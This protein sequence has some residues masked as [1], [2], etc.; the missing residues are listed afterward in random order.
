M[1]KVWMGGLF[2]WSPLHVGELEANVQHHPQHPASQP[3]HTR[4]NLEIVGAHEDVSN[5]RAH[6]AQDPLIKVG[7]F[8]L[9]QRV[10]H[11]GL[12]QP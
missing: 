12:N 2:D 4:P 5:A 6:Y 1:K 11:L 7:G 9:S 3:S 8:A 10:L